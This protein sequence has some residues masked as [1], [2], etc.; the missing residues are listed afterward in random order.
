MTP[1][2]IIQQ[3]AA[4][5]VMLALTPAG[6][7]KASGDGAAVNRWLSRIREQKPAIVATLSKQQQQC[8]ADLEARIRR[9]AA[10]WE[11][12]PDE[13]AWALACAAE[14]PEGWRKLVEFDAAWR[15]GR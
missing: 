12:S 7:I 14:D 3:A 8:P 15:A 2:T 1:A 11:Y 13:L 9:M 4:D 10:F 6:T 5:G